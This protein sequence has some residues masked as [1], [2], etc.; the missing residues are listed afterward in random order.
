MVGVASSWASPRPLLLIS[1]AGSRSP[2][3]QSSTHAQRPLNKPQVLWKCQKVTIIEDIG[4]PFQ[5][6]MCYFSGRT[7]CYK[8]VKDA[9]G[10]LSCSSLFQTLQTLHSTSSR[11]FSLLVSYGNKNFTGFGIHIRRKICWQEKF[12]QGAAIIFIR[13]V[14]GVLL[15]MSVSL[16]VSNSPSWSLTEENRLFLEAWRTVDRA[17][18]DKTFNGK[19]W[20]RYREDALRNEPMNTREETYSWLNH[21]NLS[22]RY[23]NKKNAFDVG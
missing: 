10:T 8:P 13:L 4:S 5:C 18:Y 14:V 21:S 6:S 17:Y 12:R 15:V 22:S 7:R 19:S 11:Y 16:T 23:G 1:G 2:R 3:A 20:F 9:E